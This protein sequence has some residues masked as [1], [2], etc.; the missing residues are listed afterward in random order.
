[1]EEKCAVCG[2][3]SSKFCSKCKKVYYCCVDHQK[4]DRKAHKGLC[5]SATLKTDDVQGRHFV[6]TKNIAPGEQIFSEKA[7]VV[8]PSGAE[9]YLHKICLGCYRV[10]KSN[11][12]C[13]KCKWPVCNANCEQV[14]ES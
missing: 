13:R 8:G 14:S 3:E 6:A 5:F 10:V 4:A 1:M 11:Y 7:L 9:K 12:V 2:V